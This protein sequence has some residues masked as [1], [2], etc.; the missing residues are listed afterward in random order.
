MKRE[1]WPV[2]LNGRTDVLQLVYIPNF[3]DVGWFWHDGERLHLAQNPL[4]RASIEDLIGDFADHWQ[5]DIDDPMFFYTISDASQMG[6]RFQVN[7]VDP[8]RQQ[9]PA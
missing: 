6:W 1:K 2:D 4:A 5:M 9:R 8:I 3:E 7:P